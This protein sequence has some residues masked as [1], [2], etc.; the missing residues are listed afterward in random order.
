MAKACN[1]ITYAIDFAL[2]I[3]IFFPFTLATVVTINLIENC[4]NFRLQI[5]CYCKSMKIER[6]NRTLQIKI[7]NSKT[8]EYNELKIKKAL[9]AACATDIKEWKVLI[10]KCNELLKLFAFNFLF[11]WKLAVHGQA[12]SFSQTDRRY[13]NGSVHI[14]KHFARLFSARVFFFSL[15]S[16]Q[17]FTIH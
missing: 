17:I 8:R 4:V 7:N 16:T 10:E 9:H 12:Q 3:S 6:K 14:H 5:P 15:C 13:I 1:R 11:C 2:K